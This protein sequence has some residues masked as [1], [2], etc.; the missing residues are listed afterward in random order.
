LVGT[1]HFSANQQTLPI[2]LPVVL[3]IVIAYPDFQ[4]AID[5]ILAWQSS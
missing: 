2:P 4:L 3:A 5:K 1:D